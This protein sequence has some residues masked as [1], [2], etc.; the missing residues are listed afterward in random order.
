MSTV[1]ENGNYALAM[2]EYQHQPLDFET[3][4]QRFLILHPCFGDK[5]NDDNHVRCSLVKQSLVDADP[6]IAVKNSRGYRL[7]TLPIEIDG[8]ALLVPAAVEAFLRYYRD[9]QEPIRLWIRNICLVEPDQQERTTYWTRDFVDTMYALASD[10][11][12]MNEY[13]AKMVDHGENVQVYNSK[14]YARQRRWNEI[15]KSLPGPIVFPNRL[16]FRPSP[17]QLM[18]YYPYAPLDVV[19]DEIRVLAVAPAKDP[20]AP[21]VT[22]MSHCL[23]YDTFYHAL[24]Y[25]WGSSEETSTITLNGQLV[26][27]RQSLELALRAL[28]SATSDVDIWIDAL[29]ID[30]SNLQERNRQLARIEKVYDNASIVVS[31]VGEPDED[32]DKALDFMLAMQMPMARHDENGNWTFSRETDLA[33]VP[34]LCAALY[35]FLSRP[36]FQRIWILQELSVATVNSVMC[37]K[38]VDITF[39]QLYR[40]SSNLA[41]MLDQDHKLAREVDASYYHKQDAAT[42]P[43]AYITKIFLFKTLISKGQSTAVSTLMR[44]AQYY[45]DAWKD[46]SPGYLDCLIWSR[47]FGATDAHDKIFALWN[48]ATDTDG[49]EYS[50]NYADSVAQSYTDFVKAWSKQHGSLD[51]IAAAER[52]DR[53]A[54]FYADAASWCPDWSA[55]ST[56]SSLLRKERLPNLVWPGKLVGKLYAAD[57]GVKQTA[58]EFFTFHGDTLHATGL[59]LD[60]IKL[61]FDETE[62]APTSSTSASTIQPAFTRDGQLGVQLLQHFHDHDLTTYPDVL[63]AYTAMRHGDVPSAWPTRIDHPDPD[64]KAGSSPDASHICILDRSRHVKRWDGGFEGGAAP[65]VIRH[66]LRGRLPFVSENGYMGLAPRWVG[67]QTERPWLLGILA[68]CSVPVMLLENEDG[69]YAFGGACFVQGWM[70]GEYFTQQLGVGDFAEFWSSVGQSGVLRIV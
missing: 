69:S 25:T 51:I 23:F 27:V 47:D 26:K 2:P 7:L 19:A 41:S 70:E 24:S 55:P 14:Y 68:G 52:T 64:E 58:Q 15:N 4:E 13:L 5:K 8:K 63:Q 36:Y 32:S 43:L 60:R 9:S 22:G 17:D 66:V 59:I 11:V 10:V 42:D 44:T 38:R 20:A 53:S 49:L 50:M 34:A 33:A 6:F 31:Y 40:A 65:E 67:E 18:D 61:V 56:A 16:G 30:Q 35:R 62:D 57:G 29:C 48:L 45:N 28:R 3:D 37:G 21:L 12:D 46:N 39:E 1:D 54:H